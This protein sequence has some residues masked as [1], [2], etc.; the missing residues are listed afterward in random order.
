MVDR[1]MMM[2]EWMMDVQNNAWMD[3]KYDAK[4]RNTKVIFQ[5]KYLLKC[6]HSSI[7]IVSL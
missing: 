3:S 6:V 4:N 1:K 5:D 7:E 2:N